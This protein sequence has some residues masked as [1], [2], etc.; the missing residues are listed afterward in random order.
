MMHG[1][2]KLKSRHIYVLKSTSR[3]PFCTIFLPP[4]LSKPQ[5]CRKR[6][7]HTLPSACPPPPQPSKIFTHVSRGNNLFSVDVRT[8]GQTNTLHEAK[9]HFFSLKLCKLCLKFKNPNMCSAVQLRGTVEVHLEPMS[10][11]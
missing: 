5:F 11:F 1:N 2:I 10:K 6:T 4:V 9:C 7:P 8:D 3:I